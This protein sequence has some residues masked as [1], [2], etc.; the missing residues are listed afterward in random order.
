MWMI[1]AVSARYHGAKQESF[2]CTIMHGT[3]IDLYHD[4]VIS[5]YRTLD[6]FCDTLD[7]QSIDIFSYFSMRRTK[8]N[9]IWIPLF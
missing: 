6:P 5:C 2:I 7:L 8:K 3:Y 1:S 9:I 4:Q